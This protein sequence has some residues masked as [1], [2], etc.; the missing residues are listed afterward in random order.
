MPC[1]IHSLHMQEAKAVALLSQR[2][3]NGG[4]LGMELCPVV[5]WNTRSQIKQPV[6]CTKVEMLGLQVVEAVRTLPHLLPQVH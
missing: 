6:I 5:T 4:R 2:L 1:V 3:G